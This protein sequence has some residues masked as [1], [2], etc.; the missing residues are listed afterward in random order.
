MI[1]PAIL[2]NLRP[3]SSTRDVTYMSLACVAFLTGG[4]ADDIGTDIANI[5]TS[6]V[7]IRTEEL[8]D[9]QRITMTGAAVSLLACDATQDGRCSFELRGHDLRSSSVHVATGPVLLGLLRK[10][11]Q[12]KA[13]VRVEAMVAGSSRDLCAEVLGDAPNT[14]SGEWMPTTGDAQCMREVIEDED[15]DGGVTPTYSPRFKLRLA[16]SPTSTT[17]L[18]VKSM[19]DRRYM[20]E[21]G[22]V[23]TT[24]A[25]VFIENQVRSL[26]FSGEASEVEAILEDVAQRAAIGDDETAPGELSLSYDTSDDR[27]TGDIFWKDI[28]SGFFDVRFDLDF[29]RCP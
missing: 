4:C 14:S 9:G 15:A 25:V 20:L 21:V 24:A 13:E 27:F 28:F 10:L 22:E 12:Y 5:S 6:N 18:E 8:P 2:A 7:E 11:N 23:T 16:N 17:R 19:S 3:L 1:H 29:G 26:C